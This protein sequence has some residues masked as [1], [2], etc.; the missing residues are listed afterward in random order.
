VQT[1]IDDSFNRCNNRRACEKW[2]YKSERQV[3]GEM[4]CRV[5]GKAGDEATAKDRLCTYQYI[6][7]SRSHGPVAA[8][9]VG[10]SLRKM[11]A[12]K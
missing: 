4:Y 3:N 10:E 11:L 8:S 2:Q 1:C 7:R 5:W 12:D 9:I 6:N